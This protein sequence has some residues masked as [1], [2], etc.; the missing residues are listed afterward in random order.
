MPSGTVMDDPAWARQI[1]AA[2]ARAA[3][4]PGAYDRFVVS[5]EGLFE[6]YA[7]RST[8]AAGQGSPSGPSARRL[9]LE[10]AVPSLLA[11]AET[12]RPAIVE[13]FLDNGGDSSLPGCA[14][15]FCSILGQSLP[16]ALADERRAVFAEALR[17]TAARLRVGFDVPGAPPPFAVA[18]DLHDRAFSLSEAVE[19]YP[20]RGNSVVVEEF[21]YD[22]SSVFGV[23]RP[24]ETTDDDPL[25]RA[26]ARHCLVLFHRTVNLVPCELEV[27]PVVVALLELCDGLRT[28]EEVVDAVAVMH[29]NGQDDRE[30]VMDALRRLYALGRRCVRSNRSGMGLA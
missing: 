6:R 28:T 11:Y 20:V 8:S 29:G 15:D 21:D 17:Y 9:A 23:G 24:S 19:L 4:Q 30:L 25:T 12:V 5:W 27:N 16:A 13:Q 3:A 18:D 22:V 26:E 7:Q 14:L 2:G 10:V 1:G